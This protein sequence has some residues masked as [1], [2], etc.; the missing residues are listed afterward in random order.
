MHCQKLQCATCTLYNQC[1]ELQAALDTMK[2]IE[3]DKTGLEKLSAT[4][5]EDLAVRSCLC[6]YV[7]EKLILFQSTSSSCGDRCLSMSV[8]IHFIVHA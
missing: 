2:K 8:Y 1:R 5:Q 7:W 4:L 6:F 3:E